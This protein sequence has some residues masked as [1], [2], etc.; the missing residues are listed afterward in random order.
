MLWLHSLRDYQKK[1]TLTNRSCDCILRVDLS[2]QELHMEERAG[3]KGIVVIVD[4]PVKA[5]LSAE[6]RPQDAVVVLPGV[7]IGEDKLVLRPKGGV[8][9]LSLAE[10]RR[11]S[12][13]KV[14]FLDL[15]RNVPS[16]MVDN[17]EVRVERLVDHL[18]I[19]LV[20]DKPSHPDVV[21]P[22]DEALRAAEGPSGLPGIPVEPP[23][24]ST[25]EFHPRYVHQEPFVSRE[26]DQFLRGMH[27]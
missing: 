24:S 19:D 20:E 3:E 25:H 26:A 12:R 21:S 2:L 18:L 11:E 1:S 23:I 16:N 5:V 9:I 17:V 13:F 22:Q 7:L 15:P 14:T 10:M 4:L 6:S 27:G 8:M